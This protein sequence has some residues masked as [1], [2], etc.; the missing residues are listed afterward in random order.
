MKRLRWSGELDRPPGRFGLSTA[1][2]GALAAAAAAIALA[3][4]L[5]AAL[6]ASEHDIII[7]FGINAVLVVGLQAFVGNTGIMSFGHVAFMGLGA[8]TAGILTVPAA[9]KSVFLIDLPG[10]L[11]ST[12]VPVVF[13]VFVGGLVALACG[14]VVGPLVV[15]LPE[16]T[17]SIMT[18]ALLVVMNNVF[19][20][21]TSFTRGNQTFIGVPQAASFALVFGSFAA[22]VVLTA[23]LKWSPLGLRARAVREDSISAE[24]S[25]IRVTTARLWPFA[26]SAFVTGVGGALWALD[27]TAFSSNSFYLSQSIGAIAMLILGGYRSVT[28]AIVGA[29][30]MSVWLEL[31]RHVE[32]G[33]DVG[34]LHVRA[35]PGL[36]QLFLG[37]ALV[38]VL[39]WR[40]AGLVGAR[41][42]QVTVGNSSG[43]Q[44]EDAESSGDVSRAASAGG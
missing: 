4:V 32:N 9:E 5:A 39:R 38:I 8:Y 24:S 15:R 7:L 28:G 11:R 6:G 29:S 23:G 19:Q 37:L 22:M 17:A 26:I 1:S 10:F 35:L 12:T 18:F 31:V 2:A 40:P 42:L 36:S 16:A 44:T 21:A 30:V 34:A 25:G 13:A 14:L 27:V 3:A 41:E 20:N 43:T 33:L